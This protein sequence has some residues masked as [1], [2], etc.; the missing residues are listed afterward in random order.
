M[1]LDKCLFKLAIL[2]L[3]VLLSL[4]FALNRFFLIDMFNKESTQFRITQVLFRYFLN[5]IE[6]SSCLIG[7]R[8]NSTTDTSQKVFFLFLP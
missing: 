3:V 5:V 8:L 1:L 7:N 4:L 2:P 6:R